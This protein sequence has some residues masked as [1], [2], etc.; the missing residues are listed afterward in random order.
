MQP[1]TAQTLS[2]APHGSFPE[3]TRLGANILLLVKGFSDVS[4]NLLSFDRSV[5]YIM[6][7]IGLRLAPISIV[8][9]TNVWAPHIRG[10]LSFRIRVLWRLPCNGGSGISIPKGAGELQFK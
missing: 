5:F 1:L 9:S 3:I 7:G 4:G 10:R 2:Q 6:D 8:E